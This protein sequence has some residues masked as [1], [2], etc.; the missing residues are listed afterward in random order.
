MKY[1]DNEVLPPRRRILFLILKIAV[2]PVGLL[3]ILITVYLIFGKERIEISPGGGSLAL[4]PQA[5][6][7]SFLILSGTT[8]GTVK[9]INADSKEILVEIVLPQ[10]DLQRDSAPKETIK[11]E[12]VLKLDEKTVLKTVFS[13]DI[14]LTDI[15]I[16]NKIQIKYSGDILNP[17]TQTL[18]VKEFIVYPE[19]E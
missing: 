3:V 10:R 19:K 4:Y 14:T 2:I 11:K 5:D 18:L 12:F 13:K 16:G 6:V 8:I 15:K 7:S 9:E 1:M 17:K